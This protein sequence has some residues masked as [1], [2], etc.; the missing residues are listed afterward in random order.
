MAM[1]LNVEPDK[2]CQTLKDTVFKNCSNSELLALVVVANEYQLNPLLKEIYAFP[3]KGGGIQPVVSIDGWIKI[4]NRHPKFDGSTFAMA[5]DN[6]GL[7]VSCMA[8]IYVKGRKHPTQVTEYFDECYR[9]T[10]PWDKM[11]R[12]MLRHKALIQGARVAF[13]FSG[14]QDEDEARDSLIKHANAR[15]VK[16]PALP[17]FSNESAPEITTREEVE[18]TAPPGDNADSVGEPDDGAAEPNATANKRSPA[19]G[20]KAKTVEELWE[21]A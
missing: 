5:F 13:G 17:N 18:T 3:A 14:I 8:T 4:T 1:R 9:K 7:P 2:L 6:E 15:E 12:R 11:P 21:E 20:D 19:P 10:E 16:S